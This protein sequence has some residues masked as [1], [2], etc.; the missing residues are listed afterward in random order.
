MVHFPEA[1]RCGPF[2]DGCHNENRRWTRIG[3]ASVVAPVNDELPI[4]TKRLERV[5]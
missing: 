5:F 4:L 3:L 2:R 1:S